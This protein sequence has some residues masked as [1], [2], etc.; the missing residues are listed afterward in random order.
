MSIT[1]SVGTLAS[2]MT[3]TP[4]QQ[5][6]ILYRVKYPND[7]ASVVA[8]TYYQPTRVVC[9]EFHRQGHTHQWLLKEARDLDRQAAVLTGNKRSRAA[10]NARAIR[11]YAL[12]FAKR[13]FQVCEPVRFQLEVGPVTVRVTPDLHVVER[14]Q[15]RLIKF[16][17]TASRT[18]L[19]GLRERQ[20][21]II[22]R[23]IAESARQDG[24][25][26]K[27]STVQ[28]F[29]FPSGAVVKGP[30]AGT[31]VWKELESGCQNLAAIYPSI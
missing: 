27:A 7:A 18:T 21:K 10:S 29:D 9:K 12:H 13:E 24:F 2:F 11:R 15:E 16:E 31:R 5:R 17:M 30:L 14:G 26:V 22:G 8:R 19:P 3:G 4:D 6:Q 1:V 25:Q 23:T 28:C 20:L